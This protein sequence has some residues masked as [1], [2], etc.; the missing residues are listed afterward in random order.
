MSLNLAR[1]TRVSNESLRYR[2]DPSSISYIQ[3]IKIIGGCLC[4]YKYRLGI[5]IV[6]IEIKF[7]IWAM[8]SNTIGA[9]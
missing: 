6:A 7:C 5:T 3:A 8:I 2:T 4:T 9:A 1:A